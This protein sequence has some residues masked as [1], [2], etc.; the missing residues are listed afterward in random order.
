MAGIVAV[1]AL[2]AAR[3]VL[4]RTRSRAATRSPVRPPGRRRRGLG[5]VPGRPAVAD[6]DR[7]AG[8]LRA[9][10]QHPH[11]G[12]PRAVRERAGRAD[13]AGPRERAAGRGC[14][15]SPWW[16][17]ASWCC[18]D[19][20]EALRLV[21]YAGGAALVYLGSAELLR[22]LGTAPG[23]PEPGGP[24]AGSLV[25]AAVAAVTAVAASVDGGASCCERGEQPAAVA[26][27]PGRRLQRHARAVRPAREQR[28]V[29]RH[30]QR[31]VGGRRA[32]LGADQPAPLDPAPAARTASG[33]S[34]W[35]PTTAARGRA[36]ACSPTSPPRAVTATRWRASWTRRRW[37]RPAGWARRSRAASRAARHLAVPHALRAGRDPLHRH[38]D[39][40]EAVPGPRAPE[41]GG[42]VPGELRDRRGHGGGVP[43]DR[44]RRYAQALDRGEPLP[45]L[46]RDDPRA[47][48]GC[49]CSPRTDVEG[50]PW[51]N[52]G[53]E[54]VQDTPLKAQ[55]PQDL[56]CRPSRGHRGQPDPDAQPLDRPLPAAAERQPA[57]S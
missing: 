50:V 45:T 6:P 35:T 44:H 12:R 20:D 57:R 42:A 8:R 55:R 37:R 54:W 14:A 49:W 36:A 22:V 7:C 24:C 39:R 38:A 29:P 9:G 4:D 41:R 16:P 11:R 26:A 51:L 19:P 40:H 13:A 18:C 46:G 27:T 10:L 31:H 23:R 3:T 17:R 5:L 48:S 34:C 1:V 32:R 52:Y 33:C 30:P 28:A 53:F 15:A 2:S 25:V 47:A 21:V 56:N 43:Q